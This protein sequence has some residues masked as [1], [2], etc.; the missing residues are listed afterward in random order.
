MVE[1]HLIEP[2]AIEVAHWQNPK[3]RHVPTIFG[4]TA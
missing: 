1:L 3:R 2:L 4:A